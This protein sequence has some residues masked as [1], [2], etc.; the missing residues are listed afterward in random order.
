MNTEL[1]FAAVEFVAW[2]RIF[3][4]A[5]KEANFVF[6]FIRSARGTEPMLSRY[7]VVSTTF[8]HQPMIAYAKFNQGFPISD[9]PRKI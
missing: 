2:N 8:N 9:F 1:H 6:K 7:L 5:E 3:R 4:A